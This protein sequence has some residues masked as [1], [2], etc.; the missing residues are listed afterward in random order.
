MKK[1]GNVASKSNGLVFVDLDGNGAPSNAEV[2]ATASTNGAYLLDADRG[3]FKGVLMHIGGVDA[4]SGSVNGLFYQ[5]PVAAKVMNNLTSVI[6]RL[7]EDMTALAIIKAAASATPP[8]EPPNVSFASAER[9]LE[10][11]L[12]F[13][14][15]NLL[16]EDAFALLK[17]QQLKAGSQK[18][19]KALETLGMELKLE[20]IFKLGLSVLQG[21]NLTPLD[22][23]A[24]QAGMI[25][26]LSNK[27]ASG[28]KIDPAETTHV[29][30]LIIAGGIA[31]G[32]FSDTS[33]QQKLTLDMSGLVLGFMKEVDRIFNEVLPK[34]KAVTD[35]D[36]RD[37]LK[38][39]AVLFSVAN[40]ASVEIVRA[41]YSSTV[42][43]VV[44]SY[45]GDNL[46]KLL[47]DGGFGSNVVIGN[48]ARDVFS[49]TTGPDTWVVKVDP[50]LGSYS[51][52]AGS[53][54]YDQLLNF[55]V[56]EDRL[57][58]Q[59]LLLKDPQNDLNYNPDHDEL[60]L[61]SAGIYGDL[62]VGSRGLVINI[63]WDEVEDVANS[64]ITPILFED[65]VDALLQTMD[66]RNE[67]VAFHKNGD[68]YVVV[69]DGIVGMHRT[70]TLIKLSG[71]LVQDLASILV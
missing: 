23:V 7:K 65:A 35:A 33:T 52:A 71:V 36:V 57:N 28:L 66:T 70:D 55:S 48:F 1:S 59:P 56:Q 67:T 29:S 41:W 43:E 9:K 6:T 15:L 58:I 19:L 64:D 8:K 20:M 2:R 44:Q 30:D 12:Q 32:V 24:A 21:I 49:M 54:K 68:T 3:A 17:S 46:Q 25:A 50:D 5:A 37:L 34:N 16:K 27:V 31:S 45:T 39:V 18:Q 13:K 63:V 51:T 69:S 62:Q 42:G 53:D 4:F 14:G 60:T 26:A 40:A 47:N 22:S 38:D 10:G 11:A 61:M